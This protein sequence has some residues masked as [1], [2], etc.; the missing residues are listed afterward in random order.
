[1]DYAILI[2]ILVIYFFVSVIVFQKKFIK[3]NTSSAKE[4]MTAHF[5]QVPFI[6]F[7]KRDKELTPWII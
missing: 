6:L 7:I 5:A 2:I 1:M 4:R 3:K